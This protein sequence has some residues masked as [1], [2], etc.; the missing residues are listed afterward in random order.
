LISPS[1]SKQTVCITYIFATTWLHVVLRH[2]VTFHVCSL[3]T[4]VLNKVPYHEDTTAMKSYW[5]MEVQLHVLFDIGT[6][7]R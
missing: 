6:T 1:F 7:W 2:A 4:T 3:K 5:E